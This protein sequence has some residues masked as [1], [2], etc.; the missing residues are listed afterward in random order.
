MNRRQAVVA[1]VLVC[2]I[3]GVSFT[4]IK[5]ALHYSSPLVL[6]AARFT[7]ATA[8]IAGSLRGLRRAE[9]GGGLALG[10]LFW[11]GF[12][13]QTMGLQYTTPSRSAFL[14]ILSTPLVPALQFLTHRALPRGPTLGAIALAVAGTWLLTSPGGGGGLNRGDVLTIGCAI[15]FTGQIV[16]AGHYAARIPIGRLLA[17]ELGSCA[18][19]SLLTAPVVEAPRLVPSPPFL[20]MLAFLAFTGLWSFRTQLRAQQV[21][22]PTHTA[23]VFTL[24]PVFAAVTSFLVLGERLGPTQLLGAALILA[25]V[26]APALEGAEPAAVP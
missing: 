16:A 2:L 5:Q 24:E 17:L 25:A 8:V 19:L 1:L 3:W 15:L 7:L 12:V 20:A 21:L 4:V 13:L 23:L 10:V 18:L 11:A 9:I 6:L 26:A 22:S 14:T